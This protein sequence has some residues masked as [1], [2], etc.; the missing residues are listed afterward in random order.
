MS[1]NG[2]AEGSQWQARSAQPL[3][4]WPP[5]SISP[6]RA[7]EVSRAPSARDDSTQPD[8]GL[9]GLMA[10]DPWLP[11]V[12]HSVALPVGIVERAVCGLKR[13]W[14]RERR[15]RKVA[16]AYDMALEIARVIPRGSEVLDVGCGNGF[17]AH[18]L[19]ALLGA[20]VTGIDLGNNAEAPIDYR[21][22]DGAR[23]PAP[24]KSFSAVTLC[25]VLHHAQDPGLVLNEMRRVLRRDGL[26]VIYEDIPLSRWDR[27]V[28]KF[29][30]RQWQGRTGP[31]TFRSEAEWGVLFEAFGFEVVSERQLSRWR[32]FTHPVRRRFYVLGKSPKGC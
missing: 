9:R 8:Q 13:R 28:C 18:H 23:F 17:I 19:S 31:C 25:Y 27:L 6:V 14:H 30:N 11:S 1:A 10:A 5:T 16:R 20:S 21:Q 32:N 15:R 12:R 7:T 26:A 29:H 4:P 22:Y 3:V 2:A 24:D